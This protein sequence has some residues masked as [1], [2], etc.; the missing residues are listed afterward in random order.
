MTEATDPN[1]PPAPAQDQPAGE[2]VDATVADGMASEVSP[3]QPPPPPTEAERQARAQ[4]AR[5]PL[6]KKFGRF[7][8]LDILG[9]GG[10]AVVYLAL[11][12]IIGRKVALKVLRWDPL[13]ENDEELEMRHRFEQEF[14]AAGTLAHPNLVTIY[15]VSTDDD[16][17]TFIAMEHVDGESLRDLIRRGQ[18][19][20]PTDIAHLAVQLCAGLDYAHHAGIVHRDVKPANILLTRSGVPKITDFGVAKAKEASVHLTQTGIVVGTPHFMSPEQVTGQNADGASD[21]FS[22]AVILYQIL[23]GELPFRGNDPTSIL[24]KIVHDD[25]I[26]PT[27]LN[28]A[29]SPEVEAVLLK[30]LCKRPQ[31][32][33]PTCTDFAL[34]LQEALGVDSLNTGSQITANQIAGNQTADVTSTGESET[35]PR[36]SAATTDPASAAAKA[37]RAAGPDRDSLATWRNAAMLAASLVLAVLLGWFLV[38]NLADSQEA[39]YE[40]P[41]AVTDSVEVNSTLEITGVEEGTEIWLDGLDTGIRVPQ[42]VQLSGESGSL[43]R[44]DLMRDGKSIDSRDFTLTGAEQLS[45]QASEPTATAEPRKPRPAAARKT[46][47]STRVLEIAS[48]PPGAR[49]TLNGITLA[50][51]TPLQIEVVEGSSYDLTL[52]AEGHAPLSRAFEFPAGLDP[53]VIEQGRL[54]LQL[55][56]ADTAVVPP[57]AGFLRAG[58][59][60]YPVL[61]EV[62]GQT[63]GPGTYVEAA[64]TAAIYEEVTVTAP[65]VFFERTWKKI[66]IEEGQAVILELPEA[67][68][69]KITTW[70]ED[71]QVTIDN[72]LA[73]N[74][75]LTLSLSLGRHEFLVRWPDGT[76][77]K[78]RKRITRRT[79]RVHIARDG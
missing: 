1:R 35:D 79:D 50:E 30:A 51:P 56:P 21:Q 5:P 76:I 64:L 69:V 18:E 54:D 71:G 20:S 53:E 16:D 17:A 38:S 12:P 70:P 67:I 9:K 74:A 22:V 62:A 59:S 14:R 36:D 3:P 39:L 37:A 13:M 44:I 63:F 31:D 15:D 25:P 11:D 66:R 52:Q 29:I 4:K 47:T 8:V 49:V 45:W 24:Y 60:P 19:L 42:S 57:S 32:R 73:D 23:T 33:Y 75:P 34:A 77:Q 40:D 7:E 6:P 68:P 46:T 26:P 2:R 78:L 41:A 48:T 43:V 65:E 61:L 10:M 55:I 28:L 27:Q 72:R 58:P